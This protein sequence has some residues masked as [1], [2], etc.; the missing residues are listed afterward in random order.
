MD[1]MDHLERLSLTDLLHVDPVM[2][3]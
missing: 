1:G 3:G 2:E